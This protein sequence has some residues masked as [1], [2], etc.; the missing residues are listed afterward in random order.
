MEN[1]RKNCRSTDAD[2]VAADRPDE[3]GGGGARDL[4][5]DDAYRKRLTE[6]DDD[7]D[8]GVQMHKVPNPIKRYFKT[9]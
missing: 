1:V 9:N 4:A 2:R 6:D 3:G 8:D 7:D 5:R